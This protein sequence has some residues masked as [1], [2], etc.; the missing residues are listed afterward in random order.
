MYVYPQLRLLVYFEKTLKEH[1]IYKMNSQILFTRH[2]LFTL[3]HVCV[4]IPPPP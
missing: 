1:N 4:L 3:C 2:Q